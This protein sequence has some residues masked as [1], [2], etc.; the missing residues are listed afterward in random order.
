M[1]SIAALPLLLATLSSAQAQSLED[2]FAENCPRSVLADEA[3]VR[4]HCACVRRQII[5]TTA[6][7]EDREASF[8]L[9]G[10]AETLADMARH[11][12]MLAKLPQEIQRAIEGRRQTVQ[13]VIVPL[14]LISAATG[15]VLPDGRIEE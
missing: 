8:A 9:I 14:C 1:K 7:P 6:F 11:E 2:A 12:E 5:E 4:L 3:T 10:P 15:K 13:Q